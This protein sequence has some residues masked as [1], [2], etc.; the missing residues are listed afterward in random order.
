[1]YLIKKLSIYLIGNLKC[2]LDGSPVSELLENEGLVAEDQIERSECS[3]R[4]NTGYG[5]GSGLEIRLRPSDPRD[6]LPSSAQ[7]LHD[8][9]SVMSFILFSYR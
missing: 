9:V 8:A 3:L 5:T 7:R 1:M 6:Q 4:R 2:V